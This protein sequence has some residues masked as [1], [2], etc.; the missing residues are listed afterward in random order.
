ML[1]DRALSHLIRPSPQG[2]VLLTGLAGCLV[3]KEKDQ[4][5]GDS[6]QL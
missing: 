3:L 2:A 4:L 5:A 6:W 1:P